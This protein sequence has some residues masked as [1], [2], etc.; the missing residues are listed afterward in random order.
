[1]KINLANLHNLQEEIFR[2]DFQL[3]LR[4]EDEELVRF[5]IAFQKIVSSYWIVPETTEPELPPPF[6]RDQMLDKKLRPLETQLFNLDQK[7]EVLFRDI[8]ESLNNNLGRGYRTIA[9]IHS[10]NHDCYLQA[11]LIAKAKFDIPFCG[12]DHQ[13]GSFSMH[14][15]QEKWHSQDTVCLSGFIAHSLPQN[16]VKYRIGPMHYDHEIVW[17]KDNEVYVGS[18]PSARI[19]PPKYDY[20]LPTSISPLGIRYT[21]E[22]DMPE[23]SLV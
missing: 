3:K 10:T 22:W 15:L 17:I 14:P 7:I 11:A 4:L 19:I 12:I 5:E 9:S 1:M 21:T 23:N 20:D 16:T 13:P 8:K 6:V 18:L 2:Q